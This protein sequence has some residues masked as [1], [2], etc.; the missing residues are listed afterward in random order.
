MD[1]V[2]EKNIKEIQSEL[3]DGVML[4]GVTKKHSVEETQS[5]VDAGVYDLGEN[6]V[7]EFLAKKDEITGPVR[8]HF[9]G[10]LQTNKVKYLIGQVFLIHSVH[11]LKL[12]HTIEK[13]SAKQD[14]V[15]DVLLQFNL[16]EEDSKSGFMAGE[17]E[18]VL[19]AAAACPHVNVQGLMAIGPMTK[20]PEAIHKI[21]KQ[22]KRLY[23]TM[24]KEYLNGDN[25]IK[26][27][28]MGM[29]DD[30]P[31]AVEEGSSIVRIGRKIFKHEE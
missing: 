19:A 24:K 18:S 7:Q 29:T 31:I 8:W 16:A 13:E 9:I 22:L 23:D 11:S 20:N 10:H 27:L 14:T 5:V 30:Y 17:F 6:K 1:P 2:I 28:S 26:Y 12:L 15:T 21:F 25:D 3:P 4:V